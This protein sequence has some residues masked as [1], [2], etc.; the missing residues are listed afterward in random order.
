MELRMRISGT[1]RSN[2][3]DKTPSFYTHC[4]AIVYRK[5]KVGI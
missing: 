1:L 5:G 3:F 4:L 2:D